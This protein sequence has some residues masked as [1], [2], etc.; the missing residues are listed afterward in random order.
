[1]ETEG[2][3]NSPCLVEASRKVL[4]FS[5]P[6]ARRVVQ[7]LRRQGRVRVVTVRDMEY[8]EALLA[9][10]TPL[11]EGSGVRVIRMPDC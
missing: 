10:I 7:A 1:M 5:E 9:E 4:R 3:F 6:R 11:L 2:D 8:A